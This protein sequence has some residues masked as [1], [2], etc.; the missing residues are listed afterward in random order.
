MAIPARAARWKARGQQSSDRRNHPGGG[1]T[2]QMIAAKSVTR[3]QRG[4]ALFV[5]G[6]QLDLLPV[7]Q[8][9]P[10]TAAAWFAHRF[11]ARRFS[12]VVF[13]VA[14]FRHAAFVCGA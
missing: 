9:S 7:R 13:P 14:A 6:K 10:A 11:F 2:K 8:L 4:S 12:T 3:V 5:A 1:V